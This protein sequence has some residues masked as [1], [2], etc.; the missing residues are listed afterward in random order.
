M[1]K[2]YAYRADDGSIYFRISKFRRYGRL[3][4]IR[5]AELRAAGRVS[6]DHYED[7][8]VPNDFALWKAWD[9]EDMDVFWETELG[10]GRPGWHIECSAMS[11]KYLGSTFDIHTGGL[12]NKFPH[13]ENEIAQS[14]AATGKKFVRFWLHSQFLTLNGEPM[15]KSVGNVVYLADLLKEGRDPM[16]IRTFFLL[17]RYRDVLDL[18]SAQLDQ[19]EAQRRRIQDFVSRLRSLEGGA[20]GEGVCEELTRGFGRAMDDDLNT[21]RAFAV[22]F[23]FM[24]KAN[25]LMDEGRLGARAAS[26]IIAA[27]RKVN[28]VLGVVEFE[29]Q[30]LTAELRE[31]VAKREDA[32][33]AGDYGLADRLRAELLE[34]GVVVE[35][36]PRGPVWKKRPPS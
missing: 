9:S 26:E 17:S 20:G 16:T 5:P 21:P 13:H 3:S 24:K 15:H 29:E 27:L 2:G 30:P 1:K 25:T 33:R 35:D 32:R 14:E 6:A 36:T 31:I 28:S 7:K 34:K 23:A 18:S 11:M 19:A 12:D 22:L 4:G 8:M 10:K